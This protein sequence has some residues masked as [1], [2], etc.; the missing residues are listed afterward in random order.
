M[1][2]T[3]ASCICIL[4]T[5]YITVYVVAVTSCSVM[6]LTVW[7]GPLCFNLLVQ[8]SRIS[9]KFVFNSKELPVEGYWLFFIMLTS[10]MFN[11]VWSD[12]TNKTRICPK[13]SCKSVLTDIGC[14]DTKSFV[15]K[16]Y[17]NRFRNVEEYHYG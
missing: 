4:V 1:T 10:V 16:N 15:C 8:L 13:K 14:F 3:T 2:N 17:I 9:L 6:I 11:K 12:L 5:S 7:S